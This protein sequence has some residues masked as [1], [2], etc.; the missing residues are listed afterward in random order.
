MICYCQV[1]DYTSG[2]SATA[3]FLALISRT[4]TRRNSRTSLVA[5]KI[6]SFLFTSLVSGKDTFPVF[7]TYRARCHVSRICLVKAETFDLHISY[8]SVPISQKTQSASIMKPEYIYLWG[9]VGKCRLFLCDSN[10][11]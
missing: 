2:L 11:F 9:F 5:G 6:S 3:L 1:V 4:S 8:A 10:K 7:I